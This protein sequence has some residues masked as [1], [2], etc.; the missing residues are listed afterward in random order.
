MKPYILGEERKFQ[1]WSYNISLVSGAIFDDK[2]VGL[3]QFAAT[4]DFADT[5]VTK[6]PINVYEESD[7]Y[8]RLR[9]LMRQ[10]SNIFFLQ[11]IRKKH[12][13]NLKPTELFCDNAVGLE[14]FFNVVRKI[15]E[16]KSICG[17]GVNVKL[18]N[19]GLRGSMAS[20]R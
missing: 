10:K 2:N 7:S 4:I 5:P 14:R 1:D 3:Q 20:N 8:L 9:P 13:K 6:E 12:H 17:T 11:A 19:P 16:T 18:T 15:Y